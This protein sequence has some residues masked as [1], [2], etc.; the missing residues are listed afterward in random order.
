MSIHVK[1]CG[2]TTPD[3]MRAAVDGG[4]RYVGL[5]FYERSPRH[6]TVSLAAELART[7]PTGVRTVGLFVDPS[8]EALEHT[9]GSVPMDLIQ[10]HGTETPDRVADIR[11]MFGLPVMKAI[12]VAGPKDLA[13]VP[14]FTPSVD[15]ILFDAK[16][17]DKVVS[18]PGG[19][20]IAFDWSLLAGQAWDRPWMLSGGLTAANLS[21]AV[22]TT[23]ATEVDVSSGVEDRPGHK[24]PDLIEAFLDVARRVA[25]PH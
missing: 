13:E 15:R 20:G 14:S 17:P 5:V 22:A 6:V 16:P 19:N 11:R 23:G 2:L 24:R 8:D 21:E 4:A 18:L 10:L 12:R 7:V 9:I 3:A 25:P 1:I